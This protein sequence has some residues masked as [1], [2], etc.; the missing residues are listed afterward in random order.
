MD[1]FFVLLFSC[2][3]QN[4]ILAEG[5]CC[6]TCQA[7]FCSRGPRDCHPELAVCVNGLQNYTCHCKQGFKGDGKYCEGMTIFDWH[8]TV[9]AKTNLKF[10]QKFLLHVKANQ[11]FDINCH[12]DSII[13]FFG[14]FLFHSANL[15]CQKL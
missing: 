4:Q 2:P 14:K 11:T 6:K 5:Q 15:S 13:D 8:C 7:D 9:G 10:H 1:C 3:P 12:C